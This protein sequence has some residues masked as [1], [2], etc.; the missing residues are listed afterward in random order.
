MTPWPWFHSLSGVPIAWAVLLIP[1][2]SNSFAKHLCLMRRYLLLKRSFLSI[3]WN[4]FRQLKYCTCILYNHVNCNYSYLL[5]QSLKKRLNKSQN[6]IINSGAILLNDFI[7]SY[8]EVYK[9][10]QNCNEE[11]L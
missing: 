2:H 8:T 11:N 10:L 3:S 9:V 6:L 4:L 5:Q 7:K 1:N